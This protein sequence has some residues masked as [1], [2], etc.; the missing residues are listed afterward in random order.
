MK[1]TLKYIFSI[2]LVF[3][4]LVMSAQET[5]ANKPIQVQAQADTTVVPNKKYKD[6]RELPEAV[7]KDTVTTFQKT[8]RYGLRVGID[9]FKVTR[10]LYDKDYKGIEFTGD[11]RLTK[12]YFL[13][14]ELGNENK[15]TDDDR[16]NFTTKGSYLKAGFDYNAYENWLD[17][18]NIISIGLRYGFSSFSQQ[19]NSYKIYNST[20]Y[21]DEIP[22]IASGQK[23]NGL[24]ASWVEVVA[25]IKAKV[26]NNVFVGFS[27][28]LNTLVTN[29]KPD[30]FDNLY[31]PGFNRTYNGSF[32]VGFNYTVSYFIPIYKKKVFPVFD[33]KKPKPPT[34]KR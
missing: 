13:A 15:T 31:I 3:S 8:N 30:N 12:K 6:I 18:E 2:Y 1:H 4:I 20:P 21:F 33:P 26:F 9:L 25:G 32:G 14:A 28:R 27:L 22:E 7:S 19:L 29:K 11:Y 5:T 16:V 17:M 24:S 23:Y 34:P 10:A